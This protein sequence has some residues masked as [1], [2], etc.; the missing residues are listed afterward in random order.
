MTECSPEFYGA[1]IYAKH[2]ELTRLNAATCRIFLPYQSID[3][4]LFFINKNSIGFGLH[5]LPLTKQNT[6]IKQL[7]ISLLPNNV[8]CL[9]IRYKHYDYLFLSLPHKNQS[10]Q[11]LTACRNRIEASLNHLKYIHA[12]MQ[13]T[14]FLVLMRSLLSPQANAIEWPAILDISRKTYNQIIPAPGS[15][16]ELNRKNICLKSHDALGEKIHTYLINCTLHNWSK[17]DSFEHLDL[18]CDIITS[19]ALRKQNEL[20]SVFYN[21]RII[22][23]QN[24][25]SL[26]D[27]IL[28]YYYQSGIEL[29]CS[30]TQWLAFL[31]SLPFFMTEGYY[32]QLKTLNMLKLMSKDDVDHLMLLTE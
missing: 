7:L 15:W 23:T 3:P 4:D 20:Y 21:C 17:S 24:D 8:D 31:A 12:R 11:I 26:V 9:M 5:L 25:Y 6:T 18:S 2:N 30:Q 19:I 29:H 27:N 32:Q 16:F 22:T 28:N 10:K 13:E 14:E 1:E